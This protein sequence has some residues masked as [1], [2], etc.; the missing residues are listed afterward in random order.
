VKNNIVIYFNT[1]FNLSLIGD[2]KILEKIKRKY[3]VF[4]I[5]NELSLKKKF[6]DKSNYIYLPGTRSFLFNFYTD[7]FYYKNINIS[8]IIRKYIYLF[9]L[10]SIL[11]FPFIYFFSFFPNYIV[12]KLIYS[13]ILNDKK[14]NEVLYKIKPTLILSFS[15]TYSYSE[16]LLCKFAKFHNLK[17]IIIVNNWDNLTT[18]FPILIMPSLICLWGREMKNHFNKIFYFENK[19]P[20][21]IIGS[22]RYKNLQNKFLSGVIFKKKNNFI[23]KLCNDKKIILFSESIRSVN[24]FSVLTKIDRVISDQFPNQVLIIFRAH[25]YR[26][27][28]NHKEIFKFKFKNIIIDPSIIKYFNISKKRNVLESDLDKGFS[29][30]PFYMDKVDG[31]ITQISSFILDSFIYKIKP[32]VVLE[33]GINDQ[34][35]NS[36]K[37]EY[38]LRY[39]FKKNK[40]YTHEKNTF[41]E[42]LI[43][44]LRKVVKRKILYANWKD[45]NY[46]IDTKTN[47]KKLYSRLGV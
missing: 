18:K 32:F 26:K 21:L 8:Y 44:Y 6:K 7:L 37:N 38:Y 25:P 30:V 15:Q 9:S 47:I 16:F 43:N 14:V 40:I 10:F 20:S 22:N 36:K 23:K 5:Y 13:N 4:Y 11:K 45:I 19:C 31:I 33:G 42:E 27:I 41:D 12:K 2:N 28:E 17:S 34:F 35:Y 1:K 24:T 46:I 29:D 3:N 39:I